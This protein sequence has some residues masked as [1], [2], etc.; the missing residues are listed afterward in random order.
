MLKQK[1]SEYRGFRNPGIRMKEELLPQLGQLYGSRIPTLIPAIHAFDKAHIVML[2][3]EGLITGEVGSALLKGLRKMESEGIVEARTRVGGGLHSGEQYLIRLLGEDIG[4]RMHVARSSGDLSSVSM[5]ITQREKLRRLMRA[6]NGLRRTLIGLARE[7]TDTILPGY[8]FGQQAQPMTLAHLW[9]SWAA[10]LGRDFERLH[11]AYTRVNH[12]PAGAAIMVGSEFPVNRDRT[13]ELLGF[14]DVHENCA[15]AILE[16]TNDDSLEVPAAVSILYH[17]LAKW[18]DDLIQWSTI[19]YDFVEVPER[20]CITSSIM[21]Q[22]KNVIGPAEVK[23]A[24]AEALAGY[25]AAYHGLKGTTGMPVNERYVACEMLWKV[26]DSAVRDLGWFADLLPQLKINKAHMR[27]QSWIHWATVT[28]LAGAL[29][30]KRDLPWRTAHQVVA[31]MVR[32]CEERGL[33]PADVT[34]GLLDE[35]AMLYHEQ[36][37]GLDQQDITAALDPARFIAART[38][39]GGPAK[40]ESLRQAA[41]FEKAL[42]AHEQIVSGIDARLAAAAHNLE[43]AIDAIVTRGA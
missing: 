39:R 32:L 12:S 40:Q 19:E 25:V 23:G 16:L 21:M 26:S 10:T 34:P 17:S 15:D 11:G 2:V 8:S 38:L 5:N 35:A 14:D 41:V 29:V 1:S 22:K 42:D 37:A 24:S 33:G 43:Q 7:H 13:A 9:L 27:E 30:T 4:G 36:P 20:Y 18:A 28:D 6:V 3:E 31:I